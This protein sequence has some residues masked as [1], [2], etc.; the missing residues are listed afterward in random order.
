M[1]GIYWYRVLLASLIEKDKLVF[2]FI[3]ISENSIFK[4]ESQTASNSLPFLSTNIPLLLI[5]R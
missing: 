3:H 4:V 1:K 5:L 2:T